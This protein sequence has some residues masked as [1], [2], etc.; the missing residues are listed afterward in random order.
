MLLDCVTFPARC[1]YLHCSNIV[2]GRKYF[3]FF[4][5]L[6]CYNVLHAALLYKTAMGEYCA[7]Y[8]T[9]Y[10]WTTRVGSGVSLVVG[11][12][13]PTAVSTTFTL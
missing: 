13:H 1:L 3:Y 9:Y 6:C 7:T 2:M 5:S 10:I 12:A 11:F 4:I 8:A